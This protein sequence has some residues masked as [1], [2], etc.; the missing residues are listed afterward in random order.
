MPAR[1]KRLASE[2]HDRVGTLAWNGHRHLEIYYA[3]PGM[4]AICHTINPRLHPDD[5]AYIINDAADRVLFADTSFAAL[6]ARD[7]PPA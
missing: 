6:I 4:G 5:I 7:R 3:A 2:P 1:C